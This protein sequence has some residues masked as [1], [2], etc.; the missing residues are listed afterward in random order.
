MVPSKPLV[1]AMSSLLCCLAPSLSV[2][3]L[4]RLGQAIGCCAGV[5]VARAIVRDCYDPA[6]SA[7]FFARVSVMISAAP[8]FGPILGS[9]LQTFFGWR[10]AFV[11]LTLFSLLVWAMLQRQLR[12]T[13]R[14]RDATA[15]H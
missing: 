14:H 8:F 6:H 7:Q 12:E 9:Y 15:T 5:L 4:G 13:N 11:F 1:Y 2:L 3:L 10:A